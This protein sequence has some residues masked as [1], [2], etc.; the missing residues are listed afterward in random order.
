[1]VVTRD[2]IDGLNGLGASISGSLA[3]QRGG[4]IGSKP[5]PW[6]IRDTICYQ[7]PH[8]PIRDTTGLSGVSLVYEGTT[9]QSE[10]PPIYQVHHSPAHRSIR[11]TSNLSEAP[12][13][14]YMALPIHQ[15]HPLACQGHPLACQGHPLAC[16]GHH[17]P[18]RAAPTYQGHHQPV[19]G[20]TCL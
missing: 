9:D 20:L 3:D 4:S 7:G 15:G 6:D 14:Y 13:T 5:Y 8:W 10:A 17:W 2:V 18:M 16:R 1:M 12:P 11:A 19:R